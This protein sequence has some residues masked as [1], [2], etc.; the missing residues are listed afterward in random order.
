MERISGHLESIFKSL[1]K[2]KSYGVPQ[3]CES[4]AWQQKKMAL[5]PQESGVQPTLTHDSTSKN[6][7]CKQQ[8]DTAP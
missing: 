4:D 8:F 2:K 6:S 3:A 5:W 1:Q 7:L